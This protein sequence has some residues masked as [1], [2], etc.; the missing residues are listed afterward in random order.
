[1]K[2][3]PLV[4]RATTLS[5]KNFGGIFF[6]EAG[7]PKVDPTEIFG[8]QSFFWPKFSKARNLPLE[9]KNSNKDFP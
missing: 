5:T 6:G 3:L 4:L 7:Q 2:K 9:F 1:M 8:N